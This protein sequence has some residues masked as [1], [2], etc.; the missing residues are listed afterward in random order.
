MTARAP[1]ALRA[2]LDARLALAAQARAMDVNRL[3]RHLTFQRLLRRLSPTDGW[4]LKG[5]YLLEVRLGDVARA[6]RDLDLATTRA[7]AM[8]ELRD[9]LER[10]LAVDVDGD[11][12]VFRVTGAH[13]HRRDV[14]DA[15]GPGVQLSVSAYLAG[16]PFANVRVDIVARP[17]E[18]EGG[19][20]QVELPPVVAMPE[21]PAVVVPAVDL[22]QHA[23]EKLHALSQMHA[24]PRP[25]TRVK[26][27]VDLALLI[28]SGAL[29]EVRLRARVAAVF[30]AR[31]G[32]HA[33]SGLPSPPEFWR[34]GYA[35]LAR[36]L[37]LPSPDLDVAFTEV[38][39]LFARVIHPPTT[40][41]S[42]QEPHP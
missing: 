9:A 30:V 1:D 22:A 13:E 8:H 6:T 3:R 33:E 4:V 2:S 35:E 37:N 17:A 42:T 32:Q 28:D 41:N 15:G 20:E 36:S 21:W 34:A 27:L 10:S 26:D 19:V 16:R 7:L 5:G 39:A 29:D 24:H 12:F 38:A 31:D 25:S 11:G 18:I 40:A 14:A 23:A